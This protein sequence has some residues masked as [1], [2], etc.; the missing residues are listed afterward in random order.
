MTNRSHIGPDPRTVRVRAVALGFTAFAAIGAAVLVADA[1]QQ[2][3]WQMWD[4]IRVGLILVTTG[5]LAWGA[6]LAL[7]GLWPHSA[8]PAAVLPHDYG[9]T[10][11]L[12]PI[13]NEDPVATFARIAAMDGSI[14]A[15][16][17]DLDIVILSDTRSAEGQ[18]AEQAAFRML[19]SETQGAGR[20]YYRNR[21]DNRGRKA[22]NVEDFIRT[23]GGAYDYAVTLDADSLMSGASLREMIARME[24]DPKLG[25]LQTLPRIVGAGS[26]FGRAMQFAS[27]FHGP[28]FTR[29]LERMQGST[30]PYWGHN[31][32]IRVGAFAQSCGLPELSGR[33]PFG[34]HILSHDYVEAA[35]LA[36]GG[37]RVV[38]DSGIDGSFEEG[39]ENVLAYAKRDRRWCQGNLQHSRLILAPGLAGWS[40]YVFVQ[41]IFA[42]VV[43]VLWAAFL[44]VT[45]AGTAFAPEPNYFPDQ[46]QLFPVF[47]SDRSREITALALGIIG[48]LIMPKVAIWITSSLSG[49]AHRFGGAGRA[50]GSVVCDILLTSMLAPVMLAFQ[51]RAVLQVVSGQDGGWPAHARGE[52]ALTLGQAARAS[53]W[54]ALLGLGALVITAQL[55]PGLMPWLLPVTLPMMAAPIL[56]SWSS[57]PVRGRLFAVPEEADVP[58]VVARYRAV[59]DK[60]TAAIAPA[61]PA[62]VEGQHVPA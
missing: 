40:R 56:I 27:A 34:G 48:M 33:P 28:V 25:L 30:G 8:R 43:S 31:A 42:Y 10:A 60:W 36:R 61:A 6:A 57:Q 21:T 24:A 26:L 39:P 29:G 46:Y 18:A 9:A 47:P 5:W 20:I 52:G 55:S 62:A 54:I 2:D 23:S 1:A 22:G 51:T 15:E 50:A 13:C 41:G 59:H 35:L 11:V 14:R 3:G 49:R 16:G 44:I 58:E 53:G 7:T 32:I 17:L 45:V 19:I 12:V 38:A 4:A 37:W